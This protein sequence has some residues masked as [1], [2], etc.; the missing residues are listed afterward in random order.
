KNEKKQKKQK[1]SDKSNEWNSLE[2]HLS[3]YFD[4][5]VKFNRN[6]KGKGK[7]VI[8]FENDEELEKIVAALDKPKK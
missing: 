8:P 7:I 6:N 3:D 4:T 5:S 1:K 2:K